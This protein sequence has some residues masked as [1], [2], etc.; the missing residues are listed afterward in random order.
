MHKE[1]QGTLHH[2]KIRGGYSEKIYNSAKAQRLLSKKYSHRQLSM[3][4][5]ENIKEALQK[6]NCR[7]NDI[8]DALAQKCGYCFKYVCQL[9]PIYRKLGKSCIRCPEWNKMRNARTKKEFQKWHKLWCKKI[10]LD[11]YRKEVKP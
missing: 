10:G 8:A 9:C 6:R 3:M 11:V 5:Q 4:K 2:E 7:L 1:I